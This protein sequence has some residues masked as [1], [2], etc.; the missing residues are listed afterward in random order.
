MTAYATLTGKRNRIAEGNYVSV[1]YKLITVQQ[2]PTVRKDHFSF[3]VGSYPC[4]TIIMD[5]EQAT[6]L[7]KRLNDALIN[8][9]FMQGA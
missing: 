8:P 9:E 6:T 7:A 2:S 5:R 4:A 3:S 1:G